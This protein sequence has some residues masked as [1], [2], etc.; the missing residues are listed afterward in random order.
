MFRPGIL[1]IFRKSLK[2]K[3][4]CLGGAVTEALESSGSE[5][6][7]ASGEL[8]SFVSKLPFLSATFKLPA[9]KDALRYNLVGRL[10]FHCS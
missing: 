10:L 6:C 7:D 8:D 9:W 4:C 1:D 2:S 3:S 5:C